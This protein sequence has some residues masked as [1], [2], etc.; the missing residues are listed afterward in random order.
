MHVL[1]AVNSCAA[2]LPRCVGQQAPSQETARSHESFVAQS[3]WPHPF[4]SFEE[5][6]NQ[7]AQGNSRQALAGA[8]HASALGDVRDW[9]PPQQELGR[10]IPPG[11]VWLHSRLM[12]MDKELLALL[13]HACHALNIDAVA[14]TVRSRATALAKHVFQ[15]HAQSLPKLLMGITQHC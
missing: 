4:G 10:F 8:S 12:F 13:Q 3:S 2:V 14:Y 11:M 7:A 15:C 1:K 9:Q 5:Q 6:D